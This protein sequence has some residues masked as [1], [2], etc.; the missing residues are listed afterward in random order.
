MAEERKEEHHSNAGV[1]GIVMVIVIIILIVLWVEHGGP[2]KIDKRGIFISAPAPVGNGE[3][4]G[5][6]PAPNPVQLENT[7]A[8]P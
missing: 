1:D 8:Q 3:A 2:S 7:A 6:T 4:Y 5:P